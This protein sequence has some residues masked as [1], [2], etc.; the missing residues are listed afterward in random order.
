MINSALRSI[1]T[2]QNRNH[3]EAATEDDL[4]HMLR[5]IMRDEGITLTELSERIGISKGR[6][7][8]EMSG[9]DHLGKK[10]LAYLGYSRTVLFRKIRKNG[11]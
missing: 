2:E 5:K 6:L 4:R 7:S 3:M 9:D 10:T 1:T 8:S 11:K